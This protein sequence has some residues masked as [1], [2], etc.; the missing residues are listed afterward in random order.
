MPIIARG[1]S[2]TLD[3]TKSKIARGGP[4]AFASRRPIHLGAE[5]LKSRAERS[6]SRTGTGLPIA[7]VVAAVPAAGLS[8]SNPHS[9]QARRLSA[10]SGGDA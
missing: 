6:P 10:E 2:T 4:E 5:Q 1:V 9:L 3:M 7:D 8:H